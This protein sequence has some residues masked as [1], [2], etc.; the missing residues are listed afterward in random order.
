MEGSLWCLILHQL[1][2]AVERVCTPDNLD[3]MNELVG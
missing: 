3:V 1:F 2:A